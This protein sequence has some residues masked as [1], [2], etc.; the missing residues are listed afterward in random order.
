MRNAGPNDAEGAAFEFDLP[1]GFTISGVRSQSACGAML[2]YSISDGHH[3]HALVD[4]LDSCSL[5]FFITAAASEVAGETYGFYNTP[6]GIVRPLGISD[7]DATSSD[8]D[9]TTPGAASFECE[10]TSCNN[11]VVDNQV[12]LLEPFHE[13]GQMALVKTAQHIDTNGDGYHQAGEQLRYTFRLRNVGFV[14]IREL[15]LMDSM[16]S[17]EALN[18]DAS[19]FSPG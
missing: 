6:I 9:V 8:V 13:R 15:S 16:L 10:G 1:D 14:A 19:S 11:I 7:P 2:G 4:L 12:F 3:L 5:V 18:F 17:S